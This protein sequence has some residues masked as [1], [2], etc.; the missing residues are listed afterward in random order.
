MSSFAKSLTSA[1]MALA[2]KFADGG[3][4]SI[5]QAVKAFERRENDRIDAWKAQLAQKEAERKEA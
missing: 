4:C 1:Q 2:R 3:L 5:S